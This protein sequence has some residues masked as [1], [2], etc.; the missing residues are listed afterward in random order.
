MKRDSWIR[1]H[2]FRAFDEGVDL[3]LWVAITADVTERDSRG[4]IAFLTEL[5]TTYE[6]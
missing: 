3:G 6:E 5:T 4:T 1:I 2:H